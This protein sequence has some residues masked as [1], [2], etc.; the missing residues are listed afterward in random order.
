MAAALWFATV[1]FGVAV[2]LVAIAAGKVAHTWEK[3]VLLIIELVVEGAALL[4]L[5]GEVWFLAKTAMDVGVSAA[6][7]LVVAI[8]VGLVLV[9][10][11]VWLVWLIVANGYSLIG[12]KA[13]FRPDFRGSL[14]LA[15][16]YTWRPREL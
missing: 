11:A 16:S 15:R 7:A 4:S 13:Q 14:W 10:P 3:V 5:F 9:A 1:G 6:P 8:V 12:R 2:L